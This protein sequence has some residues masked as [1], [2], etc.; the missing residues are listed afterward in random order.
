[1]CHSGA[2][3]RCVLQHGLFC[4]QPLL[5]LLHFLLLFKYLSLA[6]PFL[7]VSFCYISLDLQI[8]YSYKL[9][10]THTTGLFGIFSISPGTLWSGNR[11]VSHETFPLSFMSFTGS[12]AICQLRIL[13][14]ATLFPTFLCFFFF[15]CAIFFLKC[16]YFLLLC[17]F[18]FLFFFF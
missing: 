9:V 17:H 14:L 11:C 6:L 2:G 3:A 5:L 8:S 18:L 12:V 10:L 7:P 13:C 16:F 15:F 4:S 1:M